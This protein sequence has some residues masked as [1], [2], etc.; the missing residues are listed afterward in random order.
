MLDTM[1]H[2]T[3]GSELLEKFIEASPDK[4]A[5]VLQSMP[6]AEAVFWISSLKSETIMLCFEHMNPQKAA[7]LLRRLPV[8]QSSHIAA[9][10]P[11]ATAALIVQNLPV[12]YKAKLIASLDPRMAKVFESVLAYGEGSAAQMMQ[13]NFLSFKTDVKVKDIILKI[14]T[15]PKAKIPFSVY[16]IDKSGRGVGI[17]RTA[18]LTVWQETALAGSVM[19]PVFEKARAED[20]RDEVI[21]IFKTSGVSVIAVID[22]DGF[23]IGIINAVEM[24]QVNEPAAK[25]ATPVTSDIKYKITVAAAATILLLLACI[26]RFTL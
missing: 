22:S 20:N 24:L 10:L 4:A 5:D 8:K 6:L 18:E 1:Q 16:I 17:I 3:S 2:K 26:W 7:H 19:T 12:H 9:R 14:R 21:N 13:S 15:L 25:Q 23:I 11:A